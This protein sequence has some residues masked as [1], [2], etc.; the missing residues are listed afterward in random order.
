MEAIDTILM[1]EGGREGGLEAGDTLSERSSGVLV[2]G[3]LPILKAERSVAELGGVGRVNIVALP[4][5]YT[6]TKLRL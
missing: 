4:F 2:P 5:I 1:D 6:T 3:G